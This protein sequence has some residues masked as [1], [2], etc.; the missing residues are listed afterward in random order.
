MREIKFRAWNKEKNIMCY[1]NQ[2]YSA[3]Y[4]DGIFSSRVGL[5]NYWLSADRLDDSYVY[6]QYTGLKDKNGK[7][8]FEGDIL[9]YIEDKIK[10]AMISFK[11][12]MFTIHRSLGGEMLCSVGYFQILDERDIDREVQVIGNIYETP[13]L[14]EGNDD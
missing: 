14:L 9:K 6:M 1:D 4:L 13:E 5:I 2:D 3:D 11:D 8:I 7:E 10:Y 12:G